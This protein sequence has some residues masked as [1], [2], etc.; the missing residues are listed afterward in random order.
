MN[1]LRWLFCCVICWPLLGSAVEGDLDPAFGDGGIF[2]GSVDALFESDDRAR[3]LVVLSDGRLRIGGATETSPGSGVYEQFVLAT[4]GTDQPAADPGFGSMGLRRIGFASDG[5]DSELRRLRVLADG[6]LLGGGAVGTGGGAA[7]LDYSVVR[8]LADG[9]PDPSFGSSGARLLDFS[10]DDSLHGL[11]LDPEG[12]ILLT[13][14]SDLGEFTTA[15]ARAVR[16]LA[17]GGDDPGFGSGGSQCVESGLGNRD[18]SLA[19]D[20][21]LLPDGRTVLAGTTNVAQSGPP[22]FDMLVAVLLSDGSL[23][24][25]FGSDGFVSIGFDLGG[26]N[27]DR[28]EAVALQADGKLLLAGSA[29][30]GNGTDI[31]LARLLPDG[32]LDLSFGNGGRAVIPVDLVPGGSDRAHAMVLDDEQRILLAGTAQRASGVEAGFVMRLLAGGTL[33]PGFGSGGIRL[34]QPTLRGDGEDS[35]ELHALTLARGSVYAAG[36]IRSTAAG[37]DHDLLVLR[38]LGADLFADGFE[39]P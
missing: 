22:S 35:A 8:L 39:S 7:N 3:A 33:D 10:S 28:A 32:S 27:A 15:C 5:A 17:D 26:F 1:V 36:R 29:W 30:A 4:V 18:I 13:G 24:T 20:S 21:L 31:A 37:L 14:Y 9:S 2:Q 23:D 25:G 34:V 19:L 38:L 6:R 12:R 11:H 16:M